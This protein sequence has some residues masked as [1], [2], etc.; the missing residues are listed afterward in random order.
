M[1]DGCHT[2]NPRECHPGDMERLF[3]AAL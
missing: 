2:C 3:L 1:Q